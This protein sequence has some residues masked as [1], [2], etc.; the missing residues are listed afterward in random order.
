ML[1][2]NSRGRGPLLVLSLAVLLGAALPAH[3]E[4]GSH[5]GSDHL[6]TDR[7]ATREQRDRLRSE[8]TVRESK[9]DRT[10]TTTSSSGATL[11]TSVQTSNSGPGSLSSGSGSSGSGSDSSG[12][13]PGGTDSRGDNSGPGSGSDDI[14][15]RMQIGRGMPIAIERDTRGREQRSG[16]VLVVSESSAAPAAR[17]AGYDVI[18]ERPLAAFNE[19]LV[20]VRIPAGQDIEATLS[21]LRTLL[22]AATVAANH[23]FRPS[24]NETGAIAVT[25]TPVGKPRSATTT[26]VGVIDTGAFEQS[27]ALQGLIDEVDAFAG[28][29][30]T[31]REHGTVVCEIAA[32]RGARLIVADVFGVDANARLIAAADAI[33]SALNW[34][35][36]KS[37]PVINISVAGPYNPILEHIIA[38]TVASGALIVAA[39]GNEGPAAAPVFPAAYA[40]V[41]A[42]TAVDERGE[43][44]RR[45]NRG[46]YVMFAARGVHV[47]VLGSA[48]PFEVSGTSFAAPVVAAEL[49]RLRSLSPSVTPATLLEDLKQSVTDL[50]A[51]GRD[52][53]YGWGRVGDLKLSN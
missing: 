29:P 5:G 10:G 17:E 15:S 16:E 21:A 38:R 34:L 8:R 44:Y 22:P 31:P 27:S 50:G 20:R 25:A 3:A 28:T 53:V 48:Q 12:P 40:G 32:S 35:V 19:V 13:G 1:P 4:H 45:A 41:V 6:A 52:P 51:R 11:D 2:R 37:T 26:R 42:V 30:Y 24:N 23:V 43:V 14:D 47:P 39:A 46:D 49:A 33:A 36:A 9:G 18:E 7:T